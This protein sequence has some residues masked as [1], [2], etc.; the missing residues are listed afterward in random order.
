MPKRTDLQTVPMGVNFGRRSPGLGG[1]NCTPKHTLASLCPQETC[2]QSKETPNYWQC[3]LANRLPIAQRLLWRLRQSRGYN[4]LRSRWRSFEKRGSFDQAVLTVVNEFLA[5]PQL[6]LTLTFHKRG[7]IFIHVA[8]NCR[9]RGSAAFFA[10]LG[11]AFRGAIPAIHFRLLTLLA[12][13]DLHFIMQLRRLAD[14][15]AH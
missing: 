2:D 12:L 11:I 10:E 3:R 6:V 15:R 4:R 7:F 8:P 1:Q 9:W 13:A 5:R 14:E